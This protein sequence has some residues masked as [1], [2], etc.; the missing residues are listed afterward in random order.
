MDTT[1]NSLFD[2]EILPLFEEYREDWLVRA[3]E[4]AREL[5][6][7]RGEVTADDVRAHVPPPASIDGRVMGALFRPARDWELV[8]Y[9]RSRRGINHNRPIGVFRLKGA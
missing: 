2:T 4:V 3:R 8:R 9:E 1:A 5:A 6:A 7:K